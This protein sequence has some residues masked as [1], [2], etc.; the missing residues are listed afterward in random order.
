MCHKSI[1]SGKEQTAFKKQKEFRDKVQVEGGEAAFFGTSGRTTGFLLDEKQ[2]LR[3][4]I[5][6]LR[7]FMKPSE[8]SNAPRESAIHPVVQRAP[9]RKVAS[10]R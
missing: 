3:L 7:V 5:I 6:T 10:Q 9:V 8:V 1:A 2:R 4:I